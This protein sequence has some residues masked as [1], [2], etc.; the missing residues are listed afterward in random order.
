MIGRG[1]VFWRVEVELVALVHHVDIGDEMVRLLDRH[2][3]FRRG[4]QLVMLSGGWFR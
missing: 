2:W 1:A 4:E 3:L